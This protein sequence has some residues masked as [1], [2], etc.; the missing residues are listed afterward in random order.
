LLRV[1]QEQEFE[2]LGSGR[3]HHVDVRLVAA[4]NRDLARMVAQDQF[5]SDLYYRLNVFPIMLPPLRTRSEDIPALVEYF[6]G[7]FGRRLGNKIDSI[8]SEIIAAFQS[9]SWPGNVR[10]LQNLVERAVIMANDGVLANPFAGCLPE[11][12]TSVSPIATVAEHAAASQTVASPGG[13]TKLKDVERAFIVQTLEEVGWIVGGPNGAAA[14]LG[15][16][17]TTLIHRMKKLHIER[18]AQ[19]DTHLNFAVT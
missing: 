10:E 15:L 18:R 5:C 11:A 2:R 4:T 8:P 19:S 7:I 13:S 6:V 12:V 17:R 16:K 9:Y 3:T 14:K 1:L